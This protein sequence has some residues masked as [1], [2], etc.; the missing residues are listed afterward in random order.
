MP[1]SRKK[2]IR[3][4]VN[5]SPRFCNYQDKRKSVFLKILH[6]SHYYAVWPDGTRM[7]APKLPFPKEVCHIQSPC[8]LLTRGV[9]RKGQP[10]TLGFDSQLL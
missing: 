2:S 6:C 7:D 10:R 5:P 3:N 9:E 4:P 8:P 1:Q